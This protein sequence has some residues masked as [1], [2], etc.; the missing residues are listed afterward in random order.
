MVDLI[1][2]V[3]ERPGYTHS[4]EARFLFDA[5][6]AA[7]PVA[8]SQFIKEL[9]PAD[10]RQVFAVAERE[11]GTPYV[12][13]RDDPVGF[14]E[15]VLGENLWSTTRNLFNGLTT[16]KRVA[17]PSSFSTDKSHSASRATLWWPSVHP[18]GTAL[19][20]TLAPLWR[21]VERQLW[22]EIRKAHRRAGLPGDVDMTQMKM[23]SRTGV[24]TVVAYGIAAAPHNEAAVQGIHIP[25]LLIIVDEAGGLAH[26]IG[27]NLRG[28]LTGPNSRLLAIGN[29]PTDDE[30]SWFEKLC[31][32]DD[33]T[34][35]INPVLVLPIPATSTPAF[36]GEK[37]GLCGS[38]G[39]E[40]DAHPITDH[41]VDPDW[42]REVREDYG[43]DS[44]YFQAKVL[45]RFPRGAGDKAIPS[46]WVDNAVAQPEPEGT[47][48]VRLCDLAL[49]DDAR[50]DR[51]W[52]VRPGSWVRLGVD[53]AADGGDEFVIARV[54][55]DLA[56]VEHVSAGLGNSNAVDV[57]GK[58]LVEIRKAELLAA[59]LG[60]KA[61]V[62]VKVDGIGVG[63]GVAGILKKW[64]DEGVHNAEI[65]AVVVSES[66]DR[67]DEHLP[68]KPANKRAEM[69]LNMRTLVQ[70]NRQ[71]D[72]ALRLR[73][74]RQTT[75]QL[76]VPGKHTNASGKTLIEAK[77]KIK[78]K[79]LKS[80]DRAEAILL[81]AYEPAP[82]KSKRK[83][84]TLITK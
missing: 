47:D 81:A 16:H 66:T 51:T 33:S 29:P 15:D 28:L 60:T 21:Q 14:V 12:L 58:V 67:D 54:V 46:A 19:A 79:G 1:Q 78:A 49:P 52:A 44:A 50:D 42:V 24:E 75:A 68:M 69:W 70:P 84:A 3:N 76:S 43:E 40:I 77:A 32:D 18:V 25:N 23:M 11:G 5:L 83:K 72:S 63:W 74:D 45:A 9:S 80:P 13:W 39:P 22:P 30:G 57:A 36:T 71:G 10:M 20:V 64:A 59:A 56:T 61:P 65:D 82:K 7:P 35:A 27:R 48:Y 73:I 8:R 62:R 26:N 37:V 38:C 2:T 4:N 53:V 34:K 55:G 31:E 41:L 17:V 6:M